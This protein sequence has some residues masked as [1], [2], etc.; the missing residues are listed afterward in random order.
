MVS[1]HCVEK[2]ARRHCVLRSPTGV[3]APK[4]TRRR[5]V[6]RDRLIVEKLGILVH[7]KAG[8]EIDDNA[9]CNGA[10]ARCSE[11]SSCAI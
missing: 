3:I 7:S 10:D 5:A 9:I 1:H 4:W 2:K 6:V 8:A 11:E